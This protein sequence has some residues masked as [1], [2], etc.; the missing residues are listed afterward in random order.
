MGKNGGQVEI[1]GRG[2]LTI[3]AKI[4]DKLKIK[5]GDKLV[6]SSTSNGILLRKKP[7]KELIFKE[8]AGCIKGPSKKNVT[9]ESVK[10]IWKMKE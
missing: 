8:L 5:A 9:P 4:R 2:R 7:P 10:N 1:D 6:I 3:P